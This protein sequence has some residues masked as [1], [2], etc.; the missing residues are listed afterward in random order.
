MPFIIEME[1]QTPNDDTNEVSEEE[2]MRQIVQAYNAEMEE[3]YKR[4]TAARS[5]NMQPKRPE[6][7]YF[8]K[9]DSN[10]KKNFAFVRKI[11]NFSAAQ[12]PAL[13]KDLTSKPFDVILLK[14]CVD[15]I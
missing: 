14:S 7:S 13:Q 2:R 3:K 4:R 10:L 12:L 6:D 1:E 9:L 8:S 11:K 15:T 5:I